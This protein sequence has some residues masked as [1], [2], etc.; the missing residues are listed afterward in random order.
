M[1]FKNA[2]KG[3]LPLS[4]SMVC[5]VGM[6]KGGVKAC[7]WQCVAQSFAVESDV[8]GVMEPKVPWAMLLLDCG[9]FE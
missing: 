4:F 6:E 9:A 5:I 8:L 7:L 3:V 1:I 2:M